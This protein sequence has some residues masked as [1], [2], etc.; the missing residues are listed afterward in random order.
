MG[1]YSWLFF[2]QMKAQMLWLSDPVEDWFSSDEYL[3]LHEHIRDLKV[4]NDIAERC[5]KDMT[6]YAHLAKD[7]DYREDI[8][9]VVTEHR[10]LLK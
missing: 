7:G 6:E 10:K 4:V 8:L 2:N 9:Y 5:C 1:P 3:S